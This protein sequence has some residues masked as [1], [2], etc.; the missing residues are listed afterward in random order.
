MNANDGKKLE[1]VAGVLYSLY[2]AEVGGLAFNGDPLPSWEE[3][4][5]DPG[6]RKQS[7][8]WIA[9]AGVVNGC[10]KASRV[11]RIAVGRV[12][13]LG[14]YEHIRYE[15]TVDVPENASASEAIVGVEKLLAGLKP[16]RVTK[17]AR[18]ILRD[19]KLIEDLKVM[20]LA[21]FER[22][23]GS[24]VGGPAEYIKRLEESVADDKRK[25]TE[26]DALYKSVRNAFDD[27][28]GAS[29][30][31]DAKWDWDQGDDDL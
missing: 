18:D 14:N 10:R 13:N 23:H 12:Y 21:E 11:S 9:V 24:P 5:A 8:A 1:Y 3:F 16:D 4:R 15:L 17:S 30:L 7:D 28:G 31:K 20:P 22:R 6:K 27:I 26:A 25:R 29:Q 19:E 2:C